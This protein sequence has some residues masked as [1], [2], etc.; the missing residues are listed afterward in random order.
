MAS[1]DGAVYVCRLVICLVVVERGRDAHEAIV[2][3]DVASNPHVDV[4][5][6]P[7]GLPER[8]TSLKHRAVWSFALRY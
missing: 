1:Y 5:L 8:D 3:R 4:V 2:V 6:H 7:L